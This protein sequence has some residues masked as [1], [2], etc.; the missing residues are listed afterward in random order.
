MGEGEVDAGLLE[1]RRGNRQR[2]VCDGEDIVSLGG[3]LDPQWRGFGRTHRAQQ[4]NAAWSRC[5]RRDRSLHGLAKRHDDAVQHLDRGGALDGDEIGIAR[6]FVDDVEPHRDAGPVLAETS[7][8][9]DRGPHRAIAQ[10]LGEDFAQPRTVGEPV[11]H[12][13]NQA[14]ARREAAQ[15]GLQVADRGEVIVAATERARERRVHQYQRWPRHRRE[16]RAQHRPVV[17]G[18]GDAGKGKPQPGGTVAVNFVELPGCAIRDMRGEQAVARARFEDHV[19]GRGLRQIGRERADIGGGRELLPLDLLFAAHGLGWKRGGKP[20]AGTHV[21]G[22]RRPALTAQ[23]HCGGELEHL[24][25][26]ALGPGA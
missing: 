18:D 20:G 5:G 16:M 9:P 3:A 2:C 17:F 14:P 12:D 7:F 21:V 10:G 23:M 11:G 13:H 22:A 24:E 8:E 4:R 6:D 1:Q 26:L 19:G 25:A 15:R